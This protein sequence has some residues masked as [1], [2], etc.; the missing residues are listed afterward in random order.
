MDGEFRRTSWHFDF[1]QRFSNAT[2]IPPRVKVRFRTHDG[3]IE[4]EPPGLRV[5]GQLSHPGGI[6]VDHCKFVQANTKATAK[7]TIPSPS[8]MHF[9]DGRKSIDERAYPDMDGFYLDLARVYREEVHALGAA[10]C[11]YLQLDEVN[12]AY[13]CDPK[14]REQVRA[15]LG[16]DPAQLVHTYAKLINNAIAGRPAEMIVSMHLCR[17]N[18]QSAWVAEGGYDPVAEA[19]F[20]EI[21]VD[22]YFLEYDD[23]RSG[24]FEPLRFVPKG[25]IVVL[26]LVTT[27]QGRLESRSDLAH[28]I[29]QAAKFVP[30]GAIGA[31]PP[32]R[33]LQHGRR[34]QDHGRRSDRE[35]ALGPRRRARGLGW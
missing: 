29:D 26:G 20:N 33:V 16:E 12:L 1:L 8:M 7:Q 11:R 10:G 14:H 31:Q 5:D 21:A 17:G 6:F 18:F 24:G 3:D 34:Q 2:V 30:Y 35:A 28:R 13:L 15:N 22:G 27:K 32:M 4:L 25:K 9:R 23:E 19:M